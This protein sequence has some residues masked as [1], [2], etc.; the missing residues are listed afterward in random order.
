MNSDQMKI[1]PIILENIIKYIDDYVNE[2]KEIL[3]KLTESMHNISQEWEDERTFDEMFEYLKDIDSKSIEMFEE[4]RVIYK[5]F[6]NDEILDI[7]KVLGSLK[8]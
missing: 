3:T 5:K 7:K 2:Q 6:F 1:D 4:I 8:V